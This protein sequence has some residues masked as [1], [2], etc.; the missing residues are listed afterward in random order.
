MVLDRKNYT[1]NMPV[2][3]KY[4]VRGVIIKDGKVATQMARAGYYKILGGGVEPGEDFSDALIREVREE[5]GLLVRRGTIREAGEII[6]MREDIFT[7]GTKYVCH[8]YF[9][10]CDVEEEMT[11]PC[12]TASEVEE[13]YHL[14]WATPEE[15]IAGNRRFLDEPW[16]DRDTRFIRYM[17]EQKL[18]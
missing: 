7:K 17:Q 15:I 5:S 1:D 12:M 16:I 2:L 8:S 13:G 18:A 3:E 10:F 9:F 6:E 4:S 14:A 11:A